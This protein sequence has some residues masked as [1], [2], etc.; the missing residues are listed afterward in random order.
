VLITK[1]LL[2]QIKASA[3]IASLYYLRIIKNYRNQCHKMNTIHSRRAFRDLFDDII[4]KK[5]STSAKIAL[6][7]FCAIAIDSLELLCHPRKI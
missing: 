2:G 1:G 5:Y 7:I 4:S 6:S 3:A